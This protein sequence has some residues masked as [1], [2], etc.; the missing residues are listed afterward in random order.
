[1]VSFHLKL[2]YFV[3]TKWIIAPRENISK[4]ITGVYEICSLKKF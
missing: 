2:F 3:A 4:V 1:M